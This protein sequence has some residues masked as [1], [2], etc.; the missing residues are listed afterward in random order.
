LSG[1]AAARPEAMSAES[2]FSSGPASFLNTSGS[3]SSPNSGRVMT[4]SLP[5]AFE[6]TPFTRW[7]FAGFKASDVPYCWT[8]QSERTSGPTS[9]PSD[10]TE[11]ARRAMTMCMAEDV[12]HGLGLDGV[13][14]DTGR[15]LVHIVLAKKLG[16]TAVHGTLAGVGTARAI[17]HRDARRGRH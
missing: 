7:S 16:K 8:S 17:E 12:P 3:M 13:D 10:W 9:E 11:R 6:R 1:A 2:S 15:K 14:L 4:P 5:R